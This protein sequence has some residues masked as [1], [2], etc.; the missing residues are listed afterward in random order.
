MSSSANSDARGWG[1]YQ[2]I[3]SEDSDRTC[4]HAESKPTG[5][6]T[7]VRIEVKGLSGADPWQARLTQS[8]V[9]A[10]QRDAGSG[11]WW[12]A[13]VTRALRPDRRQRWL[14]GSE[15]AAVFTV[16]TGDGH[17]TADRAV[18]ATLSGRPGA[19]P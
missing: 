3:V 11:R 7:E 4:G 15:V 5:R 19:G 17:Y 14:S 12:L 16:A 18:A 2:R 6:I 13:I 1:S 8:E 10:A 9:T